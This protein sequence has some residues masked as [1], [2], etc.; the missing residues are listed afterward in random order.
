MT[1]D[2]YQVAVDILR[3]RFGDSQEVIDLHYS[4]MINLPLASSSTSS[5]RNLLDTMERHLRSLEVLKQNVNQDVFVSMIR[6]KL[7]QEVLLQL[8]IMHG[9]KNKW[10]VDTLRVKLH[11]YITAR[12]HA[13]KKEVTTDTRLPRN[14]PSNFEVK[15]KFGPGVNR[16]SDQHYW[17]TQRRFSSKGKGATSESVGAKHLSGSAEALVANTK[18]PSAPRY[19]DQCRYC[20]KRHCSDEC[21]TYRTIE[22]RKK[23]LRDSCF[24]C[25]KT[26]NLSRDCKKNKSCVYCG[27]VN[28]H[29]RS[30]CPQKFQVKLF[31]AHLS[32]E[33][34]EFEEPKEEE[35]CARENA[36]VSSG[37]IVLMQTAQAKLTNLNQSKCE[38]VRILH[39]SGSQ[40][41]YITESLAEQHQ[42]RR[43]KTE[44]IKVV[45][46]GCE[47]PKT[48]TTTQTKLSIQLNTGQ[49][50]DI[51]A[52]IVPFISGYVQRKVL[53]VCSSDNLLHLMRSL[54]MAD[55]IPS[56]T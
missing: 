25:L 22:D 47:T 29:H 50:L 23:Q 36:L 8:E 38:Q 35:S 7:P 13:E 28:T 1:N 10:T 9:S 54:D 53:N 44:E 39:D 43:E 20:D 45:T 49:H 56:Q 24:K 31:S 27:E 11:E 48:I 30:L 26:G 40:R 42:L 41:T 15:P 14:S 34:S 32:E 21:P 33:I 55:T 51:S 2:N 19:F 37:E 46:F 52:N 5:L 12:E 4:K 6:A 16:R 17:G 18:Q 3:D